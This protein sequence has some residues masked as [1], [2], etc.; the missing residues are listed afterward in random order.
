MEQVSELRLE[1]YLALHRLVFASIDLLERTLA[2]RR[3]YTEILGSPHA[4]PEGPAPP[5]MSFPHLHAH[6]IPVHQDGE[7]ARSAVVFS[8]STGVW[9][10]DDREAEAL[11]AEFRAAR[12]QA[13]VRSR[14][15]FGTCGINP[16]A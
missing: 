11:A 16:G 1:R 8:S 15:Y 3:V 9:L 14:G 5:A 4:D 13:R 2:P 10:Y 6:A 7:T 12:R